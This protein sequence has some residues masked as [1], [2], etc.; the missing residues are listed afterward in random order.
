MRLLETSV[1]IIARDAVGG[2]W[3]PIA[4]VPRSNGPAP[5]MPPGW[6]CFA[7]PIPPVQAGGALPAAD[8]LARR[9][10]L[11][12]CEPDKAQVHR[13]SLMRYICDKPL[14]QRSAR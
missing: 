3:T 9:S 4:C 7:E 8:P 6:S 11:D 10:L 13:Y 5:P 12:C 1:I 2:S 14:A